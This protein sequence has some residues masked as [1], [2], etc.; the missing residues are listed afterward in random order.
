MLAS[1]GTIVCVATEQL[2]QLTLSDVSVNGDGHNTTRQAGNADGQSMSRCKH[3][4]D[5]HRR[6]ATLRDLRV[7]SD[8]GQSRMS[9]EL[10]FILN[11]LKRWNLKRDALK[12]GTMKSE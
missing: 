7:P 12:S 10:F 11:V 8:V 4:R 3:Q 6:P 9:S 1:G 2:V 5:R